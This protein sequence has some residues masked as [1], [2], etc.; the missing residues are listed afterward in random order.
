MTIDNTVQTNMD[1]EKVYP[2]T[3]KRCGKP[4]TKQ[5]NRQEYCS[6]ECFQ[7]ARLE[8]KSI[9][10]RKRRKL[11]NN[12][13]IISNESKHFETGFLSEHCHDNFKKE[14]EA[15][16]KELKRIKRDKYV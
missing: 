10:Q 9:Y 15:I 12:G 4:F 1:G 11:I 6:D 7:Y 5:H 14:H 16:Q 3:C 8:Q 13:V 2:H